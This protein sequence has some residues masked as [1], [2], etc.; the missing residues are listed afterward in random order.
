MATDARAKRFKA[1]ASSI[2]ISLPSGHLM[3][4]QPF[5]RPLG[6]IALLCWA[7][8]S[9]GQTFAPQSQRDSR[10]VWQWSVT[11][12]SE[13]PDLGPARAFLWI[14]PD[15]T[16]VRGV[17]LAQDNM[18][19]Q[20][21][22]NNPIFRASLSDL[23]F[24]EVW[25]SPFFDHTFNF[26]K[27]A[28]QTFDRMM[29]DLATVSGYNELTFAPVVPMGHSAAASWPYYFA[30][31]NPGRTLAVLSISGQWPYY[32]DANTPDIWGSRN[33]D[34]I[35][36]LESMGEYESAESWANEGVNERKQHPQLALSMLAN[37]A[38]GHFASTDRKVEY[39]GFYLHK[40]VQ[41]RMQEDWKGDAAPKLK[42][43]KPTKTGWL[44]ERWAADRAPMAEP[45]PVGK[46]KGDPDEVFW[47]F[48]EETARVTEKYEAAYRGLKTQLVGVLQ[49]GSAIPQTNTHLQLTA[50]FE[51]DSDG[52][53]FH[54]QGAFYSI[55]PAGSPRPPTWTGLLPGAAI[56]HAAGTVTLDRIQGPFEKIGP[57]AFRVAFQRETQLNATKPYEL[58]FAATHPG[59]SAYRPA[60]QQGHLFIP[61]VNKAGQDQEITFVAI[62]DQKVGTDSIQLKANS[63]AQVPVSFYVR[64]GPAV[65][66]GDRL[67]L[68]ATPPRA[69][70]PIAVTVVAWQ[71]GRSVEPKLKTAKPVIQTFYVEK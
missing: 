50:K 52:V 20:A 70:F 31:W 17:V 54:L 56:G 36:L 43:I 9:L 62:P 28:G 53:T 48:D 61:A 29:K 69:K 55:V 42:P 10:V 18:E 5:V 30:A 58:V 23:G 65:I 33:V 16:L 25:V 11:V 63:S 35:P 15:C 64:E 14:P 38:Q 21:I 32:R 39:L 1:R 40:A 12:Q 24:A 47:Y 8:S 49:D 57:Q 60:V 59:D 46:Y 67:T 27:G 37:P 4:L 6:I 7:A 22:L 66:D 3:I 13:H 26:D 68:T 2:I 19:E 71:Y 44:L 51:P 45:A 34:S 41:Y